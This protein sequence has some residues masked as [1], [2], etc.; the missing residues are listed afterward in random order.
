MLRKISI[1]TLCFL[2]SS[3]NV[4]ARKVKCSDFTTQAEAQAYMEQNGAYWL[5]RDKDGEAC[6]CL[7]GGSKHG[8]SK[9]KK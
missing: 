2:L 9:C 8:T 7:P 4:Y 5:D 1:L 6:E 3:P